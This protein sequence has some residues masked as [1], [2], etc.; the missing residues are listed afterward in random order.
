MSADH[1]DSVCSFSQP[2]AAPAT[3]APGTAAPAEGAGTAPS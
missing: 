2:T 3:A 1:K